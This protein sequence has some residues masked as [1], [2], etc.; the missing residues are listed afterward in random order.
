M[1]TLTAVGA[2]LLGAALSSWLTA[3]FLGANSPQTEAR[4]R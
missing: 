3:R 4:T 1:L 2:F